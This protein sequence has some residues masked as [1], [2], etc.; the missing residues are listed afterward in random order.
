[1][2]NPK[3]GQ[4]VWDKHDKCKKKVQSIPRNGNN[5][6][7]IGAEHEPVKRSEFIF[8]IPKK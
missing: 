5:L 7:F 4:F 2:E 6:Y 1:M 8:P 3:K